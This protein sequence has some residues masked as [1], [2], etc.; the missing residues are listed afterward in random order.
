MAPRKK[1]NR[2]ASVSFNET[3]FISKATEDRFHDRYANRPLP[4]EKTVCLFDFSESPVPGWFER[5]GWTP[6]LLATGNV[7]IELV[8]EFYA[9]LIPTPNVD[10]SF[11]SYVRSHEIY[12]DSI[13]VSEFLQIPDP[14]IYDY[15][16]NIV[17]KLN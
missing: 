6:M 14:V 9:N 13:I 15:L 8:Q 3:R 5:R 4:H 11:T 7:C 12:F 2:G 16:C 1:V 10:S 17:D